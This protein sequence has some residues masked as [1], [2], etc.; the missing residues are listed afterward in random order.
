MLTSHVYLYSLTEPK[1]KPNILLKDYL[2]TRSDSFVSVTAWMQIL[3]RELGSVIPR[4][5]TGVNS[6]NQINRLYTPIGTQAIAEILTKVPR[7]KNLFLSLKRRGI[8]IPKWAFEISLLLLLAT[9]YVHRDEVYAFIYE[10]DM[11]D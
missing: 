2:Y 6:I 1:H 8:E 7:Y 5:L 4:S 11:A 10:S 3:R 9:K